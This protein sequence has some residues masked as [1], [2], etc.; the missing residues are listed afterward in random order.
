MLSTT[1]FHQELEQF[2]LTLFL[3]F[4]VTKTSLIRQGTT[5]SGT[6]EKL[7]MPGLLFHH[8]T[9]TKDYIHDLMF[10]WVHYVPIAPDLR[11]LREKFEWAE[12]HPEAAKR[13][14]RQGSELMRSL[15]T[16]E[17]FEGMYEKVFVENVER[18]IDAYQPVRVSHP[19]KDP[20]YW[21]EIMTDVDILHDLHPVRSTDKWKDRHMHS[22][23]SCGG[24]RGCVKTGSNFSPY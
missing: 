21:R 12:S 19:D 23:F 10:P 5:W 16:V 1:P 8:E 17:G 18:V 3:I 6:T 9:P 24:N 7:A 20:S 11:D 14:A 2:T 15:G 13:I 4:F 22:V